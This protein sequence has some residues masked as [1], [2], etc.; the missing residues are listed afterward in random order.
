MNPSSKAESAAG[1]LIGGWCRTGSEVQSDEYVSVAAVFPGYALQRPDRRCR[2][3]N[4]SSI[5]TFNETGPDDFSDLL[6]DFE[7]AYSILEQDAGYI[8]SDNLQDRS[9]RAGLSLAGWKPGRDMEAQTTE[10]WE[11]DWE[12]SFSPVRDIPTGCQG[13]YLSDLTGREL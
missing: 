4:Y 3:S 8:L 13:L 1:E 10:W 9:V 2:Y 12:Y 7:D 5:E 6:S 11:F